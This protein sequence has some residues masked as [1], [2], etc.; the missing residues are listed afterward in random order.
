[1]QNHLTDE[2]RTRCGYTPHEY[3]QFAN[4]LAER[5]GEVWN[6]RYPATGGEANPPI[7]YCP[8]ALLD[9]GNI[10][11]DLRA[12]YGGRNG[13]AML[14]VVAG[15]AAQIGWEILTTNLGLRKRPQRVSAPGL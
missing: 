14:E 4:K 2:E 15:R 7:S 3:R 11:H 12:L 9:N 6:K 5:S 1:M 8:A 13:P 10:E